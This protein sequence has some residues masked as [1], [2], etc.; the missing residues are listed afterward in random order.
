MV[1]AMSLSGRFGS[2]SGF[3]CVEM[4]IVRNMH[5]DLAGIVNDGRRPDERFVWRL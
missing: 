3:K 2:A 1:D 5:N 4:E